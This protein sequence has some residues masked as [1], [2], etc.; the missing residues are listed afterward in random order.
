MNRI[1]DE[2]FLMNRIFDEQILMNRI[3]DEQFLMNRISDEQFSVQLQPTR[4]ILEIAP[5]N[6]QRTLASFVSVEVEITV[7]YCLFGNKIINMHMIT[8]NVSVSVSVL[9]DTLIL[10]ELISVASSVFLTR[11][12]LTLK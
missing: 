9:A 10:H 1:F 12:G 8:F 6:L 11:L 5:A 3:F 7:V 4:I 2:Q